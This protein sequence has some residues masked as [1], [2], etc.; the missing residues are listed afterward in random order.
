[1]A[2]RSS[3]AFRRRRRPGT[4][5]T[6]GS[7]WT[8]AGA[9]V[10]AAVRRDQ[11]QIVVEPSF[12]QSDAAWWSG[13]PDLVSVVVP[14]RNSARTIER[15]LRSIRAQSHPEVELIVVDNDSDDATPELAVGIA[16]LVLHAG[17]ERRLNATSAPPMPAARSSLSS[18]ATWSSGAE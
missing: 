1:M 9:D 4:A 7:T 6:G 10:I 11:G 16:D 17:P 18:T 3:A 5:A 12:W 15:C 2:T 14:T 8:P 13:P